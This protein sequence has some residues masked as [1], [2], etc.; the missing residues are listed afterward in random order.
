MT[1]VALTAEGMP[2][3]LVRGTRYPLMFSIAD[4]KAWSEHKDLTYLEV[5]AKGWLFDQL[6]YDDLTWLLERALASGER[7]RLMFTGP[8]AHEIPADLVASIMDNA[9]P[10][11]IW[12]LLA[13]VWSAPPGTKKVDP[14][15]ALP[16]TGEGSSA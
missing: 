15:T 12:L 8:P 13:T 3:I 9:H 5:V 4:V 6:S 1:D 14:Q 10:Q 2:A 11:E 16:P 7:R